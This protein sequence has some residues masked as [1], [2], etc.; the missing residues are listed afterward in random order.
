MAATPSPQDPLEVFKQR[1]LESDVEQAQQINRI[2]AAQ[3]AQ[4]A[5]TKAEIGKAS[6][7]VGRLSKTLIETN[8]RFS[9]RAF[10]KASNNG[11]GDEDEPE[12]EEE[13]LAR[14]ETEVVDSEEL[15]RRLERD[16]Q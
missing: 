11:D 12:D 9:I 8:T 3:R 6:G 1:L 4:T 13:G 15:A 5:R 7:A 14:R 10:K 16:G 2:T